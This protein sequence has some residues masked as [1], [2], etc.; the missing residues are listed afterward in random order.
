MS[1]PG[2]YPDPTGRNAQRY[3]DGNNWTDQVVT[4]SGGQTTDPVSGPAS[5]PSSG[6][7][8]GSEPTQAFATPPAAP[9]TA[10]PPPST[11]PPS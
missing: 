11:P 3:F 7:A 1:Q 2:W 4:P 9:P 8:P 10:A 5:A 6:P